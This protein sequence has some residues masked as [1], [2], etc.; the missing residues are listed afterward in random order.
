M[1][2]NLW[3]GCLADT[4]REALS[5]LPEIIRKSPLLSNAALNLGLPNTSYVKSLKRFR[6]LSKCI[7]TAGYLPHSEPLELSE[8]E[9]FSCQM[10]GYSGLHHLR[11]LAAYVALER[12]LYTP[13]RE[14]P[15]E[16]DNVVQEYYSIVGNGDVSDLPFQHLMLHGDSEGYYVPQD[17][18][19]VIDPGERYFDVVGGG[20]GSAYRL[21]AECRSLADRI[22]LPLTLDA[23]APEVWAATGTSGTGQIKWQ[24]FGMESFSCIR[25]IRACEQSIKTGAAVAFC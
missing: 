9:S 12:E 11:R 22:E 17:F 18:S 6:T 1:G 20:I 16:D 4:R 23:E 8:E 10:W 25:L 3:V 5:Q 24:Y 14:L 13:A 2:L 7:V 15:K 19:R 21:L